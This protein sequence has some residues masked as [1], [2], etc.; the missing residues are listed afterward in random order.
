[1]RNGVG[2]SATIR[3][4]ACYW[5]DRLQW[6]GARFA[7]QETS[8]REQSGSD[9]RLELIVKMRN[10]PPKAQEQPMMLR[11]MSLGRKLKQKSQSCT[12]RNLQRICI[13]MTL[14]HGQRNS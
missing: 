6:I 1:M 11:F 4:G 9:R 13:C 10:K 12:L 2:R 5:M 14:K 8:T 7:I 3:S